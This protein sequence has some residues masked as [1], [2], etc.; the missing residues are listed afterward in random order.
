MA[1]HRQR[2]S[3]DGIE[4]IVAAE[5]L[6]PGALGGLKPGDSRPAPTDPKAPSTWDPKPG[7][8]LHPRRSRATGRRLRPT[9]AA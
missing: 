7:Q 2:R 6:K 8:W 3:C 5:E 1:R 4:T 9:G